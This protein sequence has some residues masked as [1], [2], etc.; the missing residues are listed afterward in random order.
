MISVL[1]IPCRKDSKMFGMLGP[2]YSIFITKLVGLFTSWID[3]EKCVRS[4]MQHKCSR[5]RVVIRVVRASVSVYTHEW[6]YL[7]LRKKKSLFIPAYLVMIKVYYGKPARRKQGWVNPY[8]TNYRRLNHEVVVMEWLRSQ[9][10]SEL[11]F[12]GQGGIYS[13]IVFFVIC[14]G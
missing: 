9:I 3:I 12:Q 13:P 14:H 5:R 2:I 6:G 1:F 11:W 8:E 7:C 10:P 4:R